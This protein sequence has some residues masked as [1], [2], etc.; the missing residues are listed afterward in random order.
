MSKTSELLKMISESTSKGTLYDHL[1]PKED[2]EIIKV[3]KSNKLDVNSLAIATPKDY[4][5]YNQLIDSS[6]LVSSGDTNNFDFELRRKGSKLF[7]TIK[8]S[9]NEVSVSADPSIIDSLL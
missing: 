7:F 1:D 3:A 4:N 9:S 2:G 5:K 6:T 8:W